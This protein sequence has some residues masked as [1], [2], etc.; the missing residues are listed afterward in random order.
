MPPSSKAEISGGIRKRLL[1]GV[2]FIVGALLLYNFYDFVQEPRDARSET[3]KK[4]SES[5]G[6]LVFGDKSH[7]NASCVRVVVM[8]SCGW[9]DWGGAQLHIQGPHDEIRYVIDP[10]T[11]TESTTVAEMCSRVEGQYVLTA[12]APSGKKV[13]PGQEKKVCLPV[14]L[15]R[16]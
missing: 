14:L 8:H 4:S 3:P 1:W 10:A 2:A 5:V 7:S 16:M 11:L 13:H 6:T 12:I 9:S 15:L